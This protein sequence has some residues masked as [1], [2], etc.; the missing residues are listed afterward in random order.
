MHGCRESDR[1]TARRAVAVIILGL[2]A[3]NGAS[4][5]T[6]EG[7]AAPP[8]GEVASL[9]GVGR[10][11]A[12]DVAKYRAPD[13]RRWIRLSAVYESAYRAS[14]EDIIAALWDFED[15]PK[16]FSRI[17]SVRLRSDTGTEAVIEQRTGIRVLGFSYLSDLVFREKLKREG[18]RSAI[19][20][21]ET[22]EVDDTTLSSRGSWT[23]EEGSDGS[24]PLTY[25][26]YALESCVEPKFPAQEFIM[27]RFGGGDLRKLMRE[28]GEATARRVKKG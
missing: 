20:D 15:A 7:E 25:V 27:R 14:M 19:I 21:F 17:E 2:V 13:G 4:A 23:L 11:L 10:E 26:R 6:E 16:T 24:G 28:L 8:P 5:A 18:P 12:F 3:A 22:I 1:G 9:V